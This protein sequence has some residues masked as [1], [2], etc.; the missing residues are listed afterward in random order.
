MTS[1][2]HI[3][4]GVLISLAILRLSDCDPIHII[5]GG[6]LGSVLP[7]LDT[8]QSWIAQATP[9]V[10]DLLRMTAKGSKGK[11]KKVHNTLKHRG[12]LTHSVFTII[13]FCALWYVW[14]NDFT[15]GITA[16]VVSHI[17]L[18]KVTKTG[19]VTTGGKRE[20]W[21]YNLLWVLNIIVWRMI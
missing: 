4:G 11:S 14:Q 21:V 5:A 13:I 18:D 16:G 2:T 7:D 15:L 10:D 19:I 8:E 12:L 3:A 9:W 20:D 6:I 17:L 1:R